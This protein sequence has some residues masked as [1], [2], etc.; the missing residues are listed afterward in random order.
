MAF[1]SISAL[2]KS[3]ESACIEILPDIAKVR[4]EL[5]CRFAV[6]KTYTLPFLESES[7]KVRIGDKCD[8]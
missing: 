2:E 5:S 1:K 6:V 7:V 3:V 8:R 4:I